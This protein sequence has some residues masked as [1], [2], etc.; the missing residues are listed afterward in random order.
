MGVPCGEGSPAPTLLSV[1]ASLTSDRFPRDRGRNVGPREQNDMSHISYIHLRWWNCGR[2]NNLMR[3]MRH[4]CQR[5]ARTRKP[6][7]ILKHI[8]NLWCKLR[9][10]SY[11]SHQNKQ[12]CMPKLPRRGIL[13]D[14]LCKRISN[15]LK[16]S[17]LSSDSWQKLWAK[18]HLCVN[19]MTSF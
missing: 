17:S 9:P 8:T 1:E 15:L 11:M 13:S 10:L 2:G 7:I 16:R 3:F 6:S 18:A 5:F 19:S 4:P 12:L 14:K